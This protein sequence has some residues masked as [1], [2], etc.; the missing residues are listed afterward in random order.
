MDVGVFH[1]IRV[2][3]AEKN[4]QRGLVM[5]QMAPPQEKAIRV[6]AKKLKAIVIGIFQKLGLPAEDAEI[7]ADGLVYADLSGVESH[8]V[9]NYLKLF[10]VA[11]L[12]EGKINPCP[13]IQTVHETPVTALLDGDGGMGF[14]VGARAMGVAIQKAKE[15]IVG[16]V[17]VKN[18]R[19]YGMAGYYARM[20]LTH[21][22]IGLS[23]TDTDRLVLPTFGREARIGTNPISV[24]V[25]ATEEAPF[26]LDMATSTVTIGKIMLARRAG[27]RLVNGWAADQEGRPT[28]DPEVAW[29]ARN[30]LPL[31]GT[32]EQGSH[33]GYGLGVLVDILCG[34]LSGAGVRTDP[35]LGAGVAHFFGALR[36]DAFRPGE[37]FKS[38]TDRYLRMLRTTTPVEGHERVYY[39]GLPEHETRQERKQTG[40]PLHE[41]VVAELRGLAKSL[42]VEA[43]I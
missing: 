10:Y 27:T 15:S 37:A 12:K 11:G 31:G 21:D 3:R 5:R 13:Q 14:V 35:E 19:H 22:M 30:L 25:P 26:L 23:I 38:M 18:S 8:G 42:G 4:S 16:L 24:A 9:S 34:I 20:A 41:G 33:K 32:Y 1:V 28:N 29:A 17:T 43:M 7:C 39:A 36:I 2:I 40:I 6:P